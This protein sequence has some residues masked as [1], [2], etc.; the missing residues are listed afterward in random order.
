LDPNDGRGLIV[1]NKISEGEDEIHWDLQI[2]IMVQ[3]LLVQMIGVLNGLIKC[4]FKIEFFVL[5]SI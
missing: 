4:I 1:K 3:S 5:E 2:K